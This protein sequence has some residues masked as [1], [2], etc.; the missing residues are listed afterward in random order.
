MY[1]LRHLVL[2]GVFTIHTACEKEN[3]GTS[4]SA[5]ISPAGG[6]IAFENLA[7][8]PPCDASRE[9]QI[10][11]ASD[12]MKMYVCKAGAYVPTTTAAQEGGDLGDDENVAALNACGKASESEPPAEVAVSGQ[13]VLDL[14]E[15]TDKC[16]VSGYVVGYQQELPVKLAVDGSLYLDNLPPGKLDIVISGQNAGMGL[17]E[18]LKLGVRLNDVV[19]LP[20]VRREVKDVTLLPLSK[21]VGKAQLSTLSVGGDHAGILVYIPGTDYLAYTDNQGNY[22]I[23]NVPQGVH[24]LYFEKDGYHRGQAEELTVGADPLDVD[25]IK[26]ML[27]TG[28]TGT[29]SIAG[30]QKLSN[31]KLLIN[32]W[33]IHLDIVPSKGALLMMI[34]TKNDF[35]GSYW[36]PIFTS[37]TIMVNP[38]DEL[39][40]N[41]TTLTMPQY[42]S[43]YVKFA[44]ANGLESAP[45]TQSFYRDI[46]SDGFELY[47]FSF[48]ASLGEQAGEPVFEL[49]NIN[50]PPEAAEMKV[51][52]SRHWCDEWDN[53]EK[54]DENGWKPAANT[55]VF[56][57]TKEYGDCGAHELRLQVRDNSGIA[58]SS[59]WSNSQINLELTPVRVINRC[60]HDIAAT[61]APQSGDGSNGS[62]NSFRSTHVN[63]KMVVFGYKD[64]NTMSGGIY[65]PITK[66]WELIEAAGAP[67][68]RRYFDIS[69]SSGDLYVWGGENDS[70]N[71]FNEIYR[72]N[73]STKTWQEIYS[74]VNGPG[75]GVGNILAY[76]YVALTGSHLVVWGGYDSNWQL[77][78]VGYRYNLA[79]NAWEANPISTTG[80][81]Q[82]RREGYA[83]VIQDKVLMF[84]GTAAGDTKPL[85]TAFY[86]PQADTWT[87]SVDLPFSLSNNWISQRPYISVD[88]AVLYLGAYDSNY[89]PK[90]LH[91]EA[92]LGEW[93]VIAMGQNE[94]F[95]PEAQGALHVENGYIYVTGYY[96]IQKISVASGERKS[97][98]DF[99]PSSMVSGIVAP[100]GQYQQSHYNFQT[101]T[102]IPGY[103]FMFWGGVGSG[104]ATNGG[105]MVEV[106]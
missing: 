90:V 96:G 1:H 76:A 86:D 59:S 63:G 37:R 75:A 103:G 50:L 64:T 79:T 15:E 106:R 11:Y 69:A 105:I 27:A 84:G 41:C 89:N 25:M 42:G 93:G 31:G 38:T 95:Y 14:P 100:A 82:A 23:N 70:G 48:T 77:T 22:T 7:A 67:I 92:G 61:G 102:Y 74:L 97:S 5:A 53:W 56:E 46:F 44:D 40:N 60:D 73:F 83:M 71:R 99:N 80:A 62:R 45:V 24:N 19:S 9:N 57:L 94:T 3:A 33:D 91:F 39:C 2:V 26:L 47:K 101:A 13:F 43:V 65:D 81:L 58:E 78:D 51:M 12:E 21:I 87:A 36:E 66:T 6:F 88:G 30:A 85:T 4:R 55:G 52:S 18:G 54:C 17:S 35:A 28:A 16:S 98:I 20:G 29:F 104:G 68:Y 72:Y 32:T 10:Y 49:S 8:F 34:S